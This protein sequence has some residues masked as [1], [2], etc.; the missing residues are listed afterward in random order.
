MLWTSWTASVP[1]LLFVCALLAWWFI[2]PKTTH[3]NI[4]VVLGCC[5]FYWAVAPDLAQSTPSRVYHLSRDLATVLRL[6]VLLYYHANML[7][8]GFA[9]LWLAHRAV[10][11]LR[12]SVN[13]LIN[14]LGVEVP[15]SP[16]VSLAGIRADAAT[17]NW[18]R[19]LPTRPVAK[20]TIQVNGVNV[21]DSANQETAITVTGLKPN[22]FY[23][24]RVIAVGYN[25]FQAG[26]RVIRL[27][28]FAK[29]GRPQLGD[30][31]LP[32]NFVPEEQQLA[33]PG[34]ATDEDGTARSPA[35]GVE[36]ATIPDASTSHS[37][38]QNA[39]ANLG[40]RN[41]LTRKHSPST[42]SIEQTVKDAL[43]DQ[44]EQ[45]LHELGVKFESIRKE[46][47][48]IQAQIAKDEKEHKET[49]DELAEEKKVKKRIQKEKDDTTEKLKREV[50][51][52]ERAMRSAQQRKTQKEKVLK[53]R[54]AERQKLHDDM[55]KWD[56]DIASMRKRQDSF[57]QEK[58]ACQAEGDAKAEELRQEIALLQAS[59]AQ[60]EAELKEKGKEL[61]DAE[62][63]RKKL[64][65]G[66]ES[67]EWRE[68]DREIRRNWDLR[69]R[70][71]QRRLHAANRKLRIAN[72]YE[73]VLQAQLAAAQQSGLPFMYNQANSSGVDFDMTSQ[74]QLKRRSRHS[75]SLSNVAVP[76]PGQSFSMGDRPFG[77]SSTFGPSRPPT[78]PPGFAQGPFMDHAIDFSIPL[79]E[80]SHRALTG[81]APLSPSATSLLPAGMLDDLLD[82][83]PPSPESRPMRQATFGSGPFQENAPQSP[84]S[85]G[86]S[87]SLMSSPRG[88]SQ[89]LPFS[90]YGGEQGERHSLRGLRGDFGPTSSPIAQ[91]I[92]TTKQRSFL[93]WLHRGGKAADEPPALGSLK[94]SQSQSLPRPGEEV[95]TASSKRRLSFS[96][97]W[98][99]FNRN[100][101]APDVPENSPSPRSVPH[102][103]PG[104]A[105]K[106]ANSMGS[107]IF[108]TRDPSSPRPLSIASAEL[109]RPSTDHGSIWG[110]TPQANRLW[111]TE[112]S[113]WVVSRNTSRRPSLHG[114]PSLLKTTLADADDEILDESE[115]MHASPSQVGIIGMKPIS[116]TLSQRLNPAAP[117]FMT[118]FNLFRPRS[119]KDRDVDKDA[120]DP[121]DKSKGK[122]K[123]KDTRERRP[124]ESLTSSEAGAFSLDESPSESRRSKDAFS[125]GTPSLTESRES[126]SLDHPFSNTEISQSGLGLKD[127]ESG[128]RKLLRK[129]SSSKFSFSSVRGLGGKKGPNSVAGSD[130]NPS[131]D[132][133]SFDDG[134]EDSGALTLGRSYESSPSLGPMSAKSTKEKPVSWGARFSMKKKSGKEKE[135]L[136]L[137]REES[138]PSTPVVEEE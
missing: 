106:N 48:E 85:S 63:Q 15:D 16:D 108:A 59:L 52:T 75:N 83:E 2:E 57:E 49:I 29:D 20:F 86:R 124:R 76:S 96:T 47:D 26:S 92:Q 28:T 5:L 33:V 94:P 95:E 103:R 91:P 68:S 120:K 45:S 34:E 67:E 14:V 134:G 46:I 13:D 65:G 99:M 38:D 56:K 107:T 70:E 136:D 117:S 77:P 84:A 97:G 112:E 104:L 111:S 69:S 18:T 40:R 118:N 101:A 35:A 102:R 53:E 100:S 87:P 79:D 51:S 58:K 27:R 39:N 82:D 119:E 132:R 17:L 7:V 54:Q 22:H 66:E 25:N 61:K 122:G 4:I 30:G 128:L 93:P 3:V 109:P 113:P 131:I 21:G 42:A 37:R 78:I 19:P 125:V 129:G 121:K 127:Q 137:E 64:P 89:N 60:E 81:G 1:T 55:A 114:S 115:L 138:V 105:G 31:R 116:K 6:D 62:E 73:R 71:L 32:S 11:T 36:T 90:P 50:G 10:Q 80:E 135:S 41:T 44:S 130:R 9:V 74:N 43:N 72:D 98:N 110:R 12:K 8:T 123:E 24:V 23:N 88:S 133:T 126:L